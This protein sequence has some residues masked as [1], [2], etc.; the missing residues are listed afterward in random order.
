MKDSAIESNALEVLQ[1]APTAGQPCGVGNF[2]T[3]LAAELA[4]C[5]VSVRTQAELAYTGFGDV[6]LV[7]HEW[8]T[9]DTSALRSFCASSPKPVVIFGHTADV[10]G[11]D[12]VAAGYIVM[13]R[14]IA[15]ATNLPC[16][17]MHHP[18]Y[19][20]ACLEGRAQLRSRFGLPQERVVVGSSGFLLEARCFNWF[21]DKLLDDAVSRDFFVYLLAPEHRRTPFYLKHALQGL[22]TAYPQHFKYEGQ[23][24]SRSELNERLQAC[25]L[26]WC[27]TENSGSSYVSGVASDMYGSGTRLVLSNQAQ[28]EFILGLPNV[29]RAPSNRGAFCNRLFDEIST[30]QFQRHNPDPVRWNAIADQIAQFLRAC[31][32]KHDC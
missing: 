32:K 22:A 6:V 14:Q 8:S 3:G 23:F 19:V 30:G 25:D 26:L 10:S 31:L 11:F 17:I 9:I 16:L 18:S 20:P 13:N 1:I 24:L 2:A 21:A 29:V 5:G 7:Q 12:D 28:H 27:W 15:A 4:T